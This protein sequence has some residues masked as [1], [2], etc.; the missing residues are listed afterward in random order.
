MVLESLTERRIHVHVL[1]LLV[2]PC[3]VVTLAVISSVTLASYP[4]TR[5]RSTYKLGF[6]YG[7]IVNDLMAADEAT[8]RESV[9]TKE[10]LYVPEVVG[11]PKSKL[12]A[13]VE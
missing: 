2:K 13:E 11:T 7:C 9:T 6:E 10:T 3:E 5:F 1:M 8:P 12:T 4:L